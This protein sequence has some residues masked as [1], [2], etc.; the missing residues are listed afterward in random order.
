MAQTTARTTKQGKH[1]EILVD[2]DEAL[3]VRKNA[4]NIHSA[5]LTNDVFYNLKAGDVASSEDLMKAFGTDNVIEVADKIIKNGEVV[6]PADFLKKEQEQKYRQAVDFLVKNAVSPE[7]RPYTPERIMKSLEEA[8]VN[9]KNR[10]VDEQIE[11]IIQQLKKVLPIK[12]EM[13]KIK[14]SIPA[15]FTGKAYGVISQYKEK[16]DWMPNGDLHVVLKMPTATMFDF[17]DKLNAVTHG[18]ALSEELKG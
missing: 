16:E 10:P 13:K 6:L 11:E 14:V 18:S 9:V 2:L 12:I 4:G 7:G 5:V 15:Q 17:Y 1:F 8:K 3:K